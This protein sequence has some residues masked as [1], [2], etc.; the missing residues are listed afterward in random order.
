[1]FIDGIAVKK[2]QRTDRLSL[3]FFYFYWGPI[4][5]SATLNWCTFGGVESSCPFMPLLF[6]PL[7]GYHEARNSRTPESAAF[8]ILLL[9]VGTL[10]TSGGQEKKFL[11]TT[12]HQPLWMTHT[13]KQFAIIFLSLPRAFCGLNFADDKQGFEESEAGKCVELLRLACARHQFLLRHAL[14]GKGVDRHLLTLNMATQLR[15]YM[16]CFTLVACMA[17]ND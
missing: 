14:T 5:W 10:I 13:C 16:V 15:T 17:D 2:W 9:N 12:L 1:M 8:P 11:S 6:V 7:V 3:G 4:L